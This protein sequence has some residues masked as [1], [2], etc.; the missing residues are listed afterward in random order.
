MIYSLVDSTYCRITGRGV[1]PEFWDAIYAHRLPC[2]GRANEM[3]NW[4]FLSSLRGWL[5]QMRPNIRTRAYGPAGNRTY[6]PAAPR[7]NA[8]PRKRFALLRVRRIAGPAVLDFA[9][10]LCR[11]DC[12]PTKR[13]R[14]D[15]REACCHRRPGER[16]RPNAIDFGA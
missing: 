9:Y 8:F 4:S 1:T 15:R 6:A 3:I 16:S 13:V 11:R 12:A 5:L 10:W 7:R 14:I 2:T